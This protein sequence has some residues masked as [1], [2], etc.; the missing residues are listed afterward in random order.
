[1]HL[2]TEGAG[3]VELLPIVGRNL[4]EFYLLAV[5]L[6]AVKNKLSV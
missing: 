3:I 5:G 4:M 6:D 1:M 2:S